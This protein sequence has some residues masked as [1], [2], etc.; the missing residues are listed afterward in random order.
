[1]TL[2]LMQETKS[3]HYSISSTLRTECQS[4]I[5]CL[6]AKSLS[7]LTQQTDYVPSIVAV[8]T[9]KALLG[10]L[11]SVAVDFTAVGCISTRSAQVDHS[12][13]AARPQVVTAAQCS[14]AYRTSHH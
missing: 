6:A 2:V 7:Q 5:C 12:D 4:P 14:S 13:L 11:N 8:T 3:H 10:S 9:A 1:M